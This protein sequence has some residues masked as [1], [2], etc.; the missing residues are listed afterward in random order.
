M[1]MVR[2]LGLC[3]SAWAGIFTCAPDRS[4][5]PLM[6]EP[7]RPMMRPTLSFATTTST[8]TAAFAGF[9]ALE[10]W[11]VRSMSSRSRFAR[12]MPSGVPVIAMRRV[13]MARASFGSLGSGSEAICTRTPHS[14]WSRLMVS[15]PLPMTRPTMPLGTR[16]SYVVSPARGAAATTCHDGASVEKSAPPFVNANW[17]SPAWSTLSCFCLRRWRLWGS[18]NRLDTSFSAFATAS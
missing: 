3:S 18:C 9:D 1:V 11:R 14:Y 17:P 16:A 2:A 12:S 13:S 7:W 5:M 8:A 4:W 15:P 6:V 10:F